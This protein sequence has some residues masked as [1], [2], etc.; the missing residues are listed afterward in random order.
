[1]LPERT[2]E[3]QHLRF[4]GAYREHLLEM[5]K[6]VLALLRE[7]HINALLGFTRMFKA[8]VYIR[9]QLTVEPLATC[10]RRRA[11]SYGFVKQHLSRIVGRDALSQ[12]RRHTAFGPVQAP[13]LDEL[14]HIEQIF[15]GAYVTS[16]R[17]LGL[18]TAIDLPGGGAVSAE[19][20]Y[21]SFRT[22]QQQVAG[23]MDLAADCRMMVPV[24][25][26]K[27]GWKVWLFL[28]WSARKL[29]VSFF[30]KPAVRVRDADGNPVDVWTEFGDSV[31]SA[32]TPVFAEHYTSRLMD[33]EEF[34][35]HCDQYCGYEEILAHLD[36]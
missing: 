31:Y 30:E 29:T 8:P 25:P 4:S 11:E 16:L 12:L 19:V 32:A 34:R 26:E 18:S 33:R 3:A 20:C 13:L 35:A 15:W 22:W 21:L 28:C 24:C 10:Y 6:G 23:D 36:N 7:T 5:F 14:D 27:D 2:V 1:M 17:E 9:P